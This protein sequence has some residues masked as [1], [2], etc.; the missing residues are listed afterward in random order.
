M[1]EEGW[2]DYKSDFKWENVVVKPLLLAF[3]KSKILGKIFLWLPQVLLKKIW[4]A[5]VK[6][7]KYFSCSDCKT[8]VRRG[9]KYESLLH[10]FAS[11]KKNLTNPSRI[12]HKRERELLEK[13]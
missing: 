13:N 10:S 8:Q 2:K 5:A 3:E 9:Y 4:T 7:E 12:T 11:E 6:E 1:S